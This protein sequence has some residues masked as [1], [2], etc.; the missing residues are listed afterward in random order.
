M[1]NWKGFGRKA[2]RGTI[3]AFAGGTEGNNESPPIRITDV[4]ASSPVEHRL[5]TSKTF[6]STSLFG[7]IL[8]R[9]EASVTC[10]TY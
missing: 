8:C 5:N 9:N 3:L 6:H 1:M 7:E 2:N 4:L 10:N